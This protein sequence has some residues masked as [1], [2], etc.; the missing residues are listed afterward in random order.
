VLT[1]NAQ[2]F[3]TEAF[4][5]GCASD[6]YANSYVGPNGA[7]TTTS[8]GVNGSD[9]NI[10]YVSGAECG[11]SA[12]VCGSVCGATDPSLHIGSNASVLG[13]GGASYLAGGLGFWFPETNM[14]AESPVINCTGHTNIT[15]AFN[16]IENGDGVLDD[17]TLWYYDGA[18][19]TQ[20]N[21]LAKT[22]L[23]CTPQGLWT[24]FSI[25]LPPSANNNANVKIGFN[26][27]NNDDNVGTDPSIA[28]DDITLSTAPSGPPPVTSFSASDS[29]ICAGACI[30]FTDLSTN[31]PIIS[32][33][34]TFP[35]SV[36][37][38]SNVQNPVNICYNTAGTYTVT[39]ISANANGSDTATMSIIVTANPVI[40]VTPNP[41]TLCSGN[42]VLL[43]AT[44][45]NTF[46]WSPASGLSATT[47]ASV[48][49]NPSSNTTYTIT[50]TTNGCT[51]TTSV[52]I[53]VTSGITAFA[54]NDT[55]IC[56]GSSINLLATGGT[57]Y[58]WTPA[59]GLSCTNCQSP[60]ANPSST[61][62]YTV[63]VS[64][65]TC[66]PATDQITVT[67]TPGPSIT[68]V[69]NPVTLCS[70]AID[71]LDASGADTYEWSPAT[72]LNVTTGAQVIINPS[73]NT[74][75]TVTGTTAGCSSTATVVVTITS[76]ITAYAGADTSIC[77]GDNVQL[78]ATG[79]TTY[80]WSPST[81][82]SCTNCQNPVAN[83]TSTTTYTVTVSSGSCVPATD[84]ITITMASPPTAS[85]T[86]GP[87]VCAGQSLVLT[88]SGGSTFAWSTGESTASITVNPLTSTTYS[89]TASNGGACTDEATINI[90]VNALPSVTGFSD[91][92]I[93]IG[94]S[95]QLYATG[96]QTYSWSPP[97]DLSCTGCPNP[98][99]S[100]T[101]TTMYIVT[102]T[103]ANGC[104]GY[105]S[106]LVTVNMECGEIFVPNA[107]S[108]NGDGR[109]DNL[110]V[111]GN[112]I[113]FMEFSIY[114]RWG[115]K[116]FYSADPQK[117]W[118]GKRNGKMMNSAVYM[119]FL[120]AT[121]FDNTEIKPRKGDINLIH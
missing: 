111:H 14:R 57:S 88:A 99:A 75:Y 25:L 27:T 66:T 87:S 6:C 46:A 15:L 74:T 76:G 43:T 34:W 56:S 26:W 22:A 86:G 50:G 63:T 39:L 17:A 121:L 119:Y 58:E 41:V 33:N 90:L 8:T 104:I 98:E 13:D 48:T 92:T 67:V 96:A 108:P 97:N 79:G 54:G 28:V 85:I 36:T 105:D 82:L 9:A 70:G 114:D 16:Y 52:T 29:T 72:G 18:I 30:N 117:G 1:V 112:C 62:T 3:W 60:V 103:D 84:A 23:T 110:Y 42:S 109:N 65:G 19:W 20:I 106:V 113:K 95:V 71:T 118:D 81:G 12:G 78:N 11:N 59:T 5:N 51:G 21:A 31:P 4:Q 47:G 61:T 116:V 69:P 68:V 10:W 55:T 101:V 2:V 53:T 94:G 107:F 73:S 45:A 35:G 115:E 91:T 83:P 40:S 64:S 38:T 120:K 93:S 89:V 102:G 100:P 32:W 77:V 37:A 44:G 80:A 7:W 24:A 49:A